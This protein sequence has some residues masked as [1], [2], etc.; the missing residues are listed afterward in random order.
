MPLQILANTVWEDA[1]LVQV[2]DTIGGL[3][4]DSFGVEN[5][6]GGQRWHQWRSIAATTD[7]RLVYV[8]KSGNLECTHVVLSRADLHSGH[9]LLIHSWDNYTSSSTEEYDSGSDFDP[10][11]LGPRSQDYVWDLSD[12]SISSKEALSMTF[13]AGA[14]GD[15]TKIVSKLYF[16]QAVTLENPGPIQIRPVPFPTPYTAERQSHLVDEQWTFTATDIP[17][18][19]IAAFEAL[20]NLKTDPLFIYDADATLIPFGLLH[21]IVVDYTVNAFFDDKHA[22]TMNVFALRQ[23]A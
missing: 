2:T 17:R 16:S 18:A 23:W 6:T 14:G 3:T 20:P 12:A 4:A 15:Y 7:R 9:Q 22:L 13:A 19:T 10:T 21:G 1:A 8:N 5:V 11:F